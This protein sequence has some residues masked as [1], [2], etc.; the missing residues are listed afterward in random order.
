MPAGRWS[1]NKQVQ[2]N[3]LRDAHEAENSSPHGLLVALRHL[4]RTMGTRRKAL[5]KEVGIN[6]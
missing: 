3:G 1:S 6:T 5:V 2:G 4:W